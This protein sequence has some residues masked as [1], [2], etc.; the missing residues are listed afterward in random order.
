[1]IRTLLAVLSAFALLAQSSASLVYPP[2]PKGD[3]VDDYFGTKVADPYRWMEDLNSP[4]VKQ[5][6]DAENAVTAKYLAGVAVRNQLKTR[7][8]ELWNYPKVGTPRFEGGHWFYTR[9]SGLQ[10]QSVV[11]MRDTLD[12]PERVILDPNAMS[13][14]GS[15]A[16]SQWDPSPDGRHVLYGQS[17]GGSDWVTYHVK[18]IAD[19]KD[20]PDVIRFVKFSGAAWTHDGKGFFYGRYP[21]PPAGKALEA[22]VKDKKIYY[23]A[24]G[25]PQSADKVIY[26]RPEEPT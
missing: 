24:L 26:Q 5:W 4:E 21:E 19:G 7:I 9:N 8:T 15:I 1:M 12:G 6:V 22:A 18:Q 14:D 13:P 3:T 10:R 16:L 2:A 23:H 20:V 17:E 11:Y 25:T